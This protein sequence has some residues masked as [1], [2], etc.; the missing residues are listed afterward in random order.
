MTAARESRDHESV[1]R[2]YSSY[3]RGWIA[4]TAPPTQLPSSPSHRVHCAPPLPAFLCSKPGQPRAHPI[5][6]ERS[7]AILLTKPLPS[8]LLLYHS[9]NISH[10]HTSEGKKV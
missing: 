2:S 4:Y 3:E 5:C 10:T 1:T 8:S 7:P 9:L 6:I